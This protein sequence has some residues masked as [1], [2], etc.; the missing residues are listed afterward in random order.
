MTRSSTQCERAPF[1]R[2]EGASTNA[3]GASIIL[4]AS[5]VASK[6]C[7]LECLQRHQAAVR[8]FARTW[9]ID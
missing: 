9:T 8:S 5:I 7:R 6:G 4:N 2:A 1:H 3:D